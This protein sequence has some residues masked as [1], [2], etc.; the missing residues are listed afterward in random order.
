M[1]FDNIIR[2]NDRLDVL[3][4]NQ[5]NELFGEQGYDASYTDIHPASSQSY[6]NSQH[7]IVDGYLNEI[8]NIELNIDTNDDD[9]D[10]F[11]L[12]I[13]ID[14]KGL[15]EIVDAETAVD[16]AGSEYSKAFTKLNGIPG[17]STVI[18][19]MGN[20]QR[21]GFNPS[22]VPSIEEV[23]LIKNYFILIIF[24]LSFK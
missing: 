20:M 7:E 6:F 21:T 24:I 16:N 22:Y 10:P 5:F 18:N 8:E 1:E 19:Q 4:I 23:N 14:L 2:Q 12:N 13:D 9:M 3:R 15:N 17:L 11:G